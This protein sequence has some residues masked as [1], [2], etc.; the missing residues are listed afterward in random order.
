MMKR[1]C[2]HILQGMKCRLATV[3]MLLAPLV[4]FNT[5]MA[6]IGTWQAYMSYYDI[7][8]IVKVD[9][10]LFVRASNSLYR[11]NMNDQSITTYDK[12]N[13]MSDTFISLIAWNKSASQLI[14]V[15]QDSNIDLLDKNGN[16]TNIS[17]LYTKT[18]TQSKTV[19]S[20][21]I[22]DKYAY[23]AT[24]YGVLIIDMKQALVTDSYMLDENVVSVGIK[25]NTIYVKTK[26]GTVMSGQQSLNLIDKHNWTTATA[27]DGMFDVD[28][29]DWDNYLETVKTLNP[30]GPKYN[31]FGYMRYENGRLYTCG[32]DIDSSSPTNVQV[33][34]DGEW[35]IYD[36]NISAINGGISKY[37]K[38]YTIDVDPFDIN[39]VVAGARTGVY[40]YQDNVPVKHYNQKNSPI[41]TAL[42]PKKY[43]TSNQVNYDIISGVKFDKE[44]NLWC[45]NSQSPSTSVLKLN[46][47]TE[48]WTVFDAPELMTFSDDGISN[49][50]QP[51]MKKLIT[52]SRGYFWFVNHF[53]NNP[54]VNLFYPTTDTT[55]YVKVFNTFIN[56]HGTT[57]NITGGVKF[58]AEDLNGDMWVG[59]S[60]GALLLKQ[61]EFTSEN[62]IFTQVVVPRNDGTNYAD[63]LLDGVDITCIAIDK[64]NRKWFG[65]NGNGVY[66]ISSDNM[67][68]E[69]H[70]EE[71]SSPLLSDNILSIAFNDK[72][73]QVFIGTDKGLCS[74]MSDA[75]EPSPE[76]TKDN[77]YAYPNPVSPGYEGLITIVGLA[78]DSDVKILSTSGQLVAQGHSKGGMFTWDGKDRQ[79]RRV[80]SGIYMVAA[81]TSEGKKGTVCKIA[82]IK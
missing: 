63:Y 12:M 42:N 14:I 10:E 18:M 57:F 22:Y 55:L 4:V 52:D 16:F 68:Q 23:L 8:Q 7:Q 40:V 80:A 9:N 76:M 75:T 37:G 41:Q 5:A 6:Q 26:G 81:A 62:P 56:Q 21:Y 11:Y 54:A 69:Q 49:K 82:I 44:G 13:G 71:A 34:V 58:V 46:M 60:D 17:S 53:W 48:E 15:Y 78:F 27:P 29:S 47:K 19:N 59:T 25:D 74:Y 72:T 32:G 3:L 20:I 2:Q 61:E 35:N 66:V 51:W 50:S 39:H 79:G 65:T 43:M 67:V 73:G 1:E 70:F 45:L 33:L 30:G 38:L 28:N 31:T 77:V 64:A 36:E 24:A